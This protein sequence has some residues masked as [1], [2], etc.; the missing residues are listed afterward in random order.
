MI[1]MQIYLPEDIEAEAKL[2]ARSEKINFSELVRE[3]LREK[4]ARKR[5]ANA[6]KKHPLSG[7]A[8]IIRG[9]DKHVSSRIDDILY[10]K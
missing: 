2:L 4:I 1:R 9:G 8:G 10:N 5:Q 7:L 3:S 6:Q